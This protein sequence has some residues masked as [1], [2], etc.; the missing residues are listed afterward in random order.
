MGERT[1]VTQIKKGNKH[2]DRQTNSHHKIDIKERLAGFVY[3]IVQRLLMLIS[4]Q[5]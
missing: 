2:T 3:S 1:D 4:N 5:K